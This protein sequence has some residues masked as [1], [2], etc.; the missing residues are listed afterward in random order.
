VF[1][2]LWVECSFYQTL[3]TDCLNLDLKY[4]RNIYIC[5]CMFR[6]AFLLGFTVYGLEYIHIALHYSCYYTW[7]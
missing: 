7:Y 4:L 3:V 2:C 6:F 1:G 5:I